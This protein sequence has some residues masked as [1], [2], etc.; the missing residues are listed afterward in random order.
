MGKSS[1]REGASAGDFTNL[2]I[3]KKDQ[4]RVKGVQD[5]ELW[6]TIASL[7]RRG[8]VSESDGRKAK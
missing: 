2:L 4:K 1:R 7:R 6:T 3:K 5:N 8:V